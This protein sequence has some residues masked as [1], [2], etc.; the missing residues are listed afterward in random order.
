VVLLIFDTTTVGVVTT[1]A[2][3]S[4]TGSVTG[5]SDGTG[6]SALFNWPSGVSIDSS[7]SFLYVA[8]SYNNKI[9][10]VVLSTGD[11]YHVDI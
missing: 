9:R 7:S 5:S 2:G 8:D 3:G 1:V 6:T 11:K 4:S 10:R